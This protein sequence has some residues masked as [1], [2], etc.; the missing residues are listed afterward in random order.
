MRRAAIQ[1]DLQR[2]SQIFAGCSAP[3]AGTLNPKIFAGCSAPDAGTCAG[4]RARG[5]GAPV[6]QGESRP[7]HAAAACR[8]RQWTDAGP[9]G[10]PAAEGRDSP[11]ES[12]QGSPRAS[13][14]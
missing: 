9:H 1:T 11:A 5:R 4:T 8:V 14:A 12:N 6:T 3:D 2:V 10:D 13:V 7:P